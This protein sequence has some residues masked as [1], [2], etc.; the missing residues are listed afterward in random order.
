MIG[1]WGDVPLIFFFYMAKITALNWVF[2]FVERF[3]MQFSRSLL[4]FP[5]NGRSFQLSNKLPDSSEP[6]K[7]E[8]F[9]KWAASN[10]WVASRAS[11]SMVSWDLQR[12][13]SLE[14][15]KPPWDDGY[16]KCGVFFCGIWNWPDVFTL[17]DRMSTQCYT[18]EMT[19]PIWWEWWKATHQKDSVAIDRIIIAC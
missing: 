14:N 7:V 10:F 1:H 3:P 17:H 9:K 16:T 5:S 8:F 15:V 6:T 19:T 2:R 13:S 11:C 12:C 18:V 4:G